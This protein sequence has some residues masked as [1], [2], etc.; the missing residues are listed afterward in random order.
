MCQ[1]LFAECLHWVGTTS[2]LTAWHRFLT[3][4]NVLPSGLAR[5]IPVDAQFARVASLARA[6]DRGTE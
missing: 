5:E 1:A 6:P 4:P 3:Y 2:P